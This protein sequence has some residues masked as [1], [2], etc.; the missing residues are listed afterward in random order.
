MQISLLKISFRS[1][2]SQ[3]LKLL[4]PKALNLLWILL[5]ACF[6]CAVGV[7]VSAGPSRHSST[8]ISMHTSRKTARGKC[9]CSLLWTGWKTTCSSSLIRAYQQHRLLRKS[10]L[11]HGHRKCSADCGFTVTTSTTRW[12][13]K[14]SWSGPRSW[15]C[16]DSACLGSLVLCAWKVLGPPAK[17]SGPGIL[18]VVIFSSWF[19]SH[20]P[21][22]VPG[23]LFSK[24]F[25]ISQ[26]EGSDMEEDHDSP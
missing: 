8:Q 15:A 18:S 20:K 6:I 4:G 13:G 5:T 17:I 25:P 7:L 26:S 23:L 10:L 16:Q 19:H 2:C 21:A 1:F 11:L 3:G 12:K 9:V 14:T 24:L 22:D